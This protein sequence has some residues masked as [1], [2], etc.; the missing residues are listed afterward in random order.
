MEK[1]YQDREGK[2]LQESDKVRLVTHHF[3]GSEKEEDEHVYATCLTSTNGS[4]Q[5]VDEDGDTWTE[6][7]DTPED[8]I[9]I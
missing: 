2:V 1:T 5:L 6:W 4:F 9:K 8:V 7:L 3:D